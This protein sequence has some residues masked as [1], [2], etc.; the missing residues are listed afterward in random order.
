LSLKPNGIVLLEDSGP[1]IPAEIK[2]RIFDPFFSTKDK[3]TGLGLATAHSLVEAQGGT[4]RVSDSE[5]GG[6]VFS[7]NFSPLQGELHD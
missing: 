7:L 3:G 5:L 1:G 2:D 4:I 6:T